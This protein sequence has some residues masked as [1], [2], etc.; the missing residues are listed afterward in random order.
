MIKTAA[1]LIAIVAAGCSTQLPQKATRPINWCEGNTG[2]ILE[3]QISIM[4]SSVPPEWSDFRTGA[5]S[6][7]AMYGETFAV[8]CA[9]LLRRDP[10]F[11]L[12]RYLS[13]DPYA[14]RC[15]FMAYGWSAPEY[16]RV[17]DLVYRFRLSD[18]NSETERKNIEQ[19]IEL[20]TGK[21]QR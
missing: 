13:G 8:S 9:Y 12:R 19:F 2:I 5:D 14:I 17:L 15:A 18:A 16:R 4:E 10:T 1:L 21:K 11:F 6:L 7:G 20:T 3:H